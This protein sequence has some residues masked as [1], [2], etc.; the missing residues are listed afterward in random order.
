MKVT[1][2]AELCDVELT[3]TEYLARTT[4]R[5]VNRVCKVVDVG[6]V[7]SD[8]W[9][10]ELAVESWRLGARISRQPGPVGVCERLWAGA[11]TVLMAELSIRKPVATPAKLRSLCTE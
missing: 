8:L 10:E 1:A 6:S 3:R 2:D 5:V 4:N 7:C 9:S 11:C